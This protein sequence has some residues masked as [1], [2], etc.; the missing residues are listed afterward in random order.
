MDLIHELDGYLYDEVAAAEEKLRI[1]LSPHSK[2]YILDLLKRLAR[3]DHLFAPLADDRPLAAIMLEAMHKN[4]FERT[5]DLRL[6]GDLSLVFAG[7]YPEHLTR[8]LMGVDYFISL[9][10]RSYGLLSE[11]CREYRS[12]RE[13]AVLYFQLFSEFM[14]LTEILT[15]MAGTMHFL[16]EKDVNKAARRWRHTRIRKYLEILARHKIV[17]V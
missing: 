14:C 16:D 13:L 9:G 10:K 5:R 4:I 7:L 1:E 3:S 8:R 15:E 11:T 2:I 12:R 17:P 6:I